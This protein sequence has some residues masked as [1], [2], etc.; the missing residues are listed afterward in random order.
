MVELEETCQSAEQGIADILDALGWKFAREG[1]KAPPFATCF[2]VLGVN[3]D[4]TGVAQGRVV[5]KNKP[6]RV[7]ALCS[8]T[9]KFILAERVE[10]G[11]AASIHGQ[12]N[13]AQNQYPGALLKPAMQFFSMVASQ[14]WN[15]DMRPALAVACLFTRAILQTSLPKTISLNDV[16]KPILVFTD[17]AWEPTSDHPAGAGVVVLDEVTNIQMVHEVFTPEALVQ[18]WKQQGKAQLIAEL[19]L[20]P[21]IVFFQNYVAL[22]R[23]RRVLLFV[24]IRDAVAK[25]TSRSLAILVLLSEMHRLWSEAQCHCWLKGSLQIERRRLSLK[26][27]A[28]AC[29]WDYSRKCRWQSSPFRGT[30]PIDLWFQMFC[31]VHGAADEQARK[32]GIV[33]NVFSIV[34]PCDHCCR[35]SGGHCIFF[36]N[37]LVLCGFGYPLLVLEDLSSKPLSSEDDL[38]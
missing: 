6:S 9:D 26:A 21:I 24:A 2:D 25:G 4:L 5:L 20:L 18:H 7:G 34:G 8:A 31:F 11:E 27:A 14:G 30:L 17:G 1:A 36:G 38:N 16:C 29:S 12:L 10:A 33:K 37:D 15:D 13:F 22:C 35:L 19:E 3:V 32:M 28:W 23:H